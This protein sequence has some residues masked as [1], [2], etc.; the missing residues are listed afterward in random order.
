M[1]IV[2]F[3]CKI[4]YL[5]YMYNDWCTKFRNLHSLH[6]L[7]FHI[8]LYILYT[9]IG[10]PNLE[11]CTHCTCCHSTLSCIYILYTMIDAPNLES[12]TH[13]TF[14]H[15][16]MSCIS[17]LYTVIDAPD[18]EICTHYTCFP[19][20]TMSTAYIHAQLTMS[21]GQKQVCTSQRIQLCSTQ[22]GLAITVL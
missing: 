1:K 13:C 10:A 3:G 11:I 20:T 17:I 19:S 12:C 16:W 4:V 22:Q 5:V 8:V 15:S 9:L 7:S 18:L 6:M 2:F 14:F 21:S